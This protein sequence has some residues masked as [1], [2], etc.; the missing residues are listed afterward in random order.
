MNVKIEGVYHRNKSNLLN[1]VGEHILTIGHRKKVTPQKPPLYLLYKTPKGQ[2]DKYI[3][4][5]YQMPSDGLKT[6]YTGDFEGREL[7]II[8]EEDTVSITAP[9]FD[10]TIKKSL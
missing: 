7:K 1:A 3:T 6:M 8:F 10:G 5:L 2:K 4:S 9:D